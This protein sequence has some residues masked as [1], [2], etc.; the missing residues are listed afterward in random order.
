MLQGA[1][2]KAHGAVNLKTQRM[3]ENCGTK[4]TSFGTL[5]ERERRWCGE[6]GKAHA[7]NLK[8]P[9]ETKKQ[10][11]HDHSSAG[12]DDGV[13]AGLDLN[14]APIR[15]LATLANH[16]CCVD[17]SECWHQARGPRPRAS[18]VNVAAQRKEYNN[19]AWKPT[20]SPSRHRVRSA[21]SRTQPRSS[22]GQN[23]CTL[24]S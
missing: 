4:I 9:A 1:C 15:D 24:R 12:A 16:A 7:V 5:A 8:R 20:R 14:Y 6:C 21:T 22:S 10:E 3:C 18:N 13:A 11:A 17:A 19:G 2:G 23:R